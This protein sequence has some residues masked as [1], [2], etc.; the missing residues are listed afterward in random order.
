MFGCAGLSSR[1]CPS[2]ERSNFQHFDKVHRTVFFMLV[3][4]L[5]TQPINKSGGLSV[6]QRLIYYKFPSIPHIPSH[7]IKLHIEDNKQHR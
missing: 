1:G 5:K 6:S 2:V 3:G 4:D 7:F